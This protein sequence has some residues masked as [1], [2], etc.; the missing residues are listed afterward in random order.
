MNG[1]AQSGA[2]RMVCTVCMMSLIS[3]RTDDSGASGGLPGGS[4]LMSTMGHV[5]VAPG[6]GEAVPGCGAAVAEVLEPTVPRSASNMMESDSGDGV[7]DGLC[8][9]S[10]ETLGG[11]GCLVDPMRASVSTAL[12][13]TLGTW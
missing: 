9:C 1:F 10:R 2:S 3:S 6:C 8:R 4:V 5:A 7:I 12:L 11:I 13:F